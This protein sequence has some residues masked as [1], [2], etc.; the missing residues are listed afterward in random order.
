MQSKPKMPSIPEPND[1]PDKMISSIDVTSKSVT[2]PPAG[3]GVISGDKIK[4]QLKDSTVTPSPA[5]LKPPKLNPSALAIHKKWQFDAEKLGGPE[6]RIVVSKLAAK[7]LIFDMLHE[8]FCPM[9]RLGYLFLANFIIIDSYTS[10]NIVLL[11]PTT[12]EHHR[13]IQGKR[14]P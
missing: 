8:S 6:A 12:T 14:E 5:P 13:N 10:M 2:P 4:I 11:C 3:N 7:K 1:S 9:V